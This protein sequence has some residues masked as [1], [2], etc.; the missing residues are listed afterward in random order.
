MSNVVDLL[1][2]P[3]DHMSWAIDHQIIASNDTKWGTASTV[4]WIISLYLS[5]LK[6]TRQ[7]HT[8]TVEK[9]QLTGDEEVMR[10]VFFFFFF[11]FV[12]II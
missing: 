1:F 6:A 2:Y 7:L 5:I 10:L 3:I 12:Q 4:C 9:S 8:L 11:F